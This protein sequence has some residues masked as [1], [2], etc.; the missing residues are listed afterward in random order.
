MKKFIDSD[1]YEINA[2]RNFLI[3]LEV[4]SMDGVLRTLSHRKWS[5]HVSDESVGNFVTSDYPVCLINAS[6]KRGQF[7]GG[8]HAMNDTVLLFPLARMAAL[9]GTFEGE[10]R[11]V[12]TTPDF[13]ALI[14]G[15]VILYS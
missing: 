2:S 5:I 15:D 7:A 13:V 3:E 4:S 6:P 10:S 14:N 11:T 8:G 9:V 12:S 1:Q